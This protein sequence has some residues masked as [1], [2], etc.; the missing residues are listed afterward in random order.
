MRPGV[1][2]DWIMRSS[3]SLLQHTYIYAA[4]FSS[5]S[6]SDTLRVSPARG[7]VKTP[8]DLRSNLVEKLYF[9]FIDKL[10]SLTK[11]WAYCFVVVSKEF[12]YYILSTTDSEIIN[13]LVKDSIHGVTFAH[14]TLRSLPVAEQ[15][16]FWLFLKN[17]GTDDTQIHCAHYC[18]RMSRQMCKIVYNNINAACSITRNK[19]E[20]LLCKALRVKSFQVCI[21]PAT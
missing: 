20:C 2:L 11:I 17:C 5:S 12:R 1:P 10:S 9:A 13:G 7:L 21:I 4:S 19:F 15:E 14:F 8:K 18:K 3:V 16:K 6:L